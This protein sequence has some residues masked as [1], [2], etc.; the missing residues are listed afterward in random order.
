VTIRWND[1]LDAALKQF[2]QAGLSYIACSS[3]MG[4]CAELC[5]KRGRQLALSKSARIYTWPQEKDT[6]LINMRA[7]GMSWKRIGKQIDASEKACLRRARRL[8]LSTQ[9]PSY[10]TA[11]R[12]HRLADLRSRKRTWAECGAALG[13]TPWAARH[14]SR[15]LKR[16]ESPAPA[17]PEVGHPPNTAARVAAFLDCPSSQN[18]GGVEHNGPLGVPSFGRAA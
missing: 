9:A 7:L 16:K 5:S 15:V 2:R 1:D 3:R 10:W 17:G 4:I 6:A 11:G 13:V 12:D 8:G 14:R 18:S